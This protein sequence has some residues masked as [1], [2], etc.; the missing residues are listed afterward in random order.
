MTGNAKQLTLIQEL[1]AVVG[2]SNTLTDNVKKQAYTKGF[3]FGSGDAVAVVKPA[4]LLEIWQVLKICVAADLA[5]IMQAANTGLTG[6]ST[7]NG[8]DYDRPIVIVN[9]MRISSIH[10]VDNA[11]QIVGL[12]GSTLFGL[13]DVLKPYGREP[14]SVIGSSCIGA[15]I[16][17]GIC[18]N[19]GGALVQRGP[20]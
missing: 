19:S 8:N 12:A 5:V 1:K 2:A 11:K 14:H 18:N 7:P 9:T 3:R 10:L 4:T 17:G 13:E 16:V 6:G 15:S 20:A